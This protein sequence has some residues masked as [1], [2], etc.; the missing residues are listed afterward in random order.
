VFLIVKVTKYVPT[1]DVS[2]V[3]SLHAG[4]VPADEQPGV[5]KPDDTVADIYFR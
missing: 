1:I 3:A 2:K 5:T 4:E